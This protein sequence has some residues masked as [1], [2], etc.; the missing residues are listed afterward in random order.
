MI[1]HTCR[2]L[3]D[4]TSTRQ[5]PCNRC[6]NESAKKWRLNNPQRATDYVAKAYAVN[7]QVYYNNRKDYNKRYKLRTRYGLTI[8]EKQALE[9]TQNGVC[10]ICKTNRKLYVD[11][12]HKTGLIRG[13]LCNN[14]NSGI[15]YFAE[16][17]TSLLAAAEYLG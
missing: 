3:G 5:Q 8:E 6:R 13:L 11:H 12:C 16:S 17:A 10:A 9:K 15:G 1:E 14:C 4:G 7:R 2:R